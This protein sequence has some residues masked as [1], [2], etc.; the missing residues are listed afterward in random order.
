MREK[1]ARKVRLISSLLAGQIKGLPV[2]DRRTFGL[3]NPFSV[4]ECSFQHF[5]LERFRRTYVH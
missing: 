5:F 1:C 3:V 4:E 2:K